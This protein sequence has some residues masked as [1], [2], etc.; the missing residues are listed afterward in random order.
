MPA[1]AAISIWVEKPLTL[2]LDSSDTVLLAVTIL[3]SMLTFGAGRTNI[4]AGVV[5]LILFA[6]YLFLAFVP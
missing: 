5:H 3:I 1:V 6:T 4:L 2:G